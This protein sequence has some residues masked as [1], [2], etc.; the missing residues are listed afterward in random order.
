MLEPVSAM[1]PVCLPRWEIAFVVEATCWLRES[2]HI[3]RVDQGV[4]TYIKDLSR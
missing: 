1:L 2:E 3:F 4:H